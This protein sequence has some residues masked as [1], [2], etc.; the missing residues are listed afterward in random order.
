[1]PEDIEALSAWKAHPDT[2][3]AA[4]EAL[5]SECMDDIEYAATMKVVGVIMRE[6]EQ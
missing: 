4:F 2:N 3:R 6:S 5:I 1:M